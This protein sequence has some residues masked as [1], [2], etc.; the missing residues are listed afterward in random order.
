MKYLVRAAKYF[1]Y[2]ALI[3]TLI[4][5]ALVLLGFVDGD[6]D[7][8]FTGGVSSIWKMAAMMAALALVYP[9]FGYGSR[10]L[11]LPGD[12]A[13]SRSSVVRVMEG[14]GYRLCKELDGGGFTLVKRSPL[15]RALKM[16]EDTLT[17]TP[18]LGGW[19]VEG[20][21]REVVRAISALSNA[22]SE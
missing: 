6:I 17:F 16:W 14:R 22:L 11:R 2:L 1:L 13:E 15:D 7:T 18:S 9:G 8:M 19:S 21:T 3:L 12:P 4:I 10:E 5:A 20:H